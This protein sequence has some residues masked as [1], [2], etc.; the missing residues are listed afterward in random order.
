MGR[1]RKTAK[2]L[3][4]APSNGLAAAYFGYASAKGPAKELCSFGTVVTRQCY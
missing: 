1:P 3:L 4:S 2:V